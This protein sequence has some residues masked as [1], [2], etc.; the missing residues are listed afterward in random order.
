MLNFVNAPI[1]KV[2][3]SKHETEVRLTLDARAVKE[4]LTILEGVTSPQETRVRFPDFSNRESFILLLKTSS[5]GEFKSMLAHP[6]SIEWVG[7][8]ILSPEKHEGLVGKIKS[9]QDFNLLSLGP[10]ARMNNLVLSFSFE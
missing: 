1:E 3:H 6:S 5:T 10:L 7:T 4:L 8:L 2:P 9:G